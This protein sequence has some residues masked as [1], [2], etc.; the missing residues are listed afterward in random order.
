M[1]QAEKTRKTRER[2][3]AAALEEFGQK[4]YATASVNSICEAGHIPKGLLY[5]NFK[6]KDELYLQCV[7]LCYDEMTAFLQARQFEIH[8]AREGLQRMLTLRQQ[9]FS[10][11]PQHA[12]I[13]FDAVLRPPRHLLAELALLRKG[14]DAYFDARFLEALHCLT[15][16]DG[17]TT[18]MALEYFWV[19]TEMF[20]AYFQK[21][22]D[23]G[24]DQHDL[25]EAH[26]GKLPEIFDIL[27]YG[28]AKGPAEGTIVE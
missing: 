1:K 8:D 22:A 26:E 27:L 18:E 5:H 28:L 21:K 2:I 9:F 7:G 6:G 10:L 15:L 17:I 19:F 20:N 25:I 23:L 3:L 12:N 11:Y 14:F 24:G 4:G 16:R 13:F